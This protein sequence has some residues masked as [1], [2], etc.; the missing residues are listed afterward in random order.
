MTESITLNKENK[1][2]IITINRPEALNALN[3]QVLEE[4]DAALNDINN[5]N[6]IKALII[7]GA[8]R[9]F[10]AG[11]DIAVQSLFDVEA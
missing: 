2:A 5:D 10:V 11:A 7:T 8:G 9:S 4:L 1:T 6:E 3:G